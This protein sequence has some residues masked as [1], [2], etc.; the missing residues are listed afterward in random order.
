MPSLSGSYNPAVGVIVSVAVMP[1]SMVPSLAS[2]PTAPSVLSQQ[3]LT[4]FPA[5][6]D[7]GASITCIADSVVKTLGLTPSGKTMMSGST[8]QGP[9]DQYTFA[10]GFIYG[11]QMNPSGTMNGAMSMKLVQGC[12]FTNHGFGFDVL[13]GRDILCSGHFSMSYD[14]HWLMSF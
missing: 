14:G 13:I 10:V 3:Q 4:F 7:T 12:E 11:A 2:N 9:V 5:L 6:I 1:P 8:G